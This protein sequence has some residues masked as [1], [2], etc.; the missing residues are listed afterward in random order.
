[1]HTKLPTAIDVAAEDVVLVLALLVRAKATPEVEG[2]T[3]EEGLLV[4]AEVRAVEAVCAVA[5]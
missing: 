5:L 1:M 4:D 2:A 3:R